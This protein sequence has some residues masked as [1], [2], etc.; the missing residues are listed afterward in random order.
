MQALCALDGGRLKHHTWSASCVAGCCN[1]LAFTLKIHHR[2]ISINQHF[3]HLFSRI[4]VAILQSCR[5]STAAERIRAEAAGPRC[6]IKP[7]SR[8]PT[9]LQPPFLCFFAVAPVIY[10]SRE[11]PEE[12]LRALKRTMSPM[13]PIVPS[14][15]NNTPALLLVFALLLPSCSRAGH[16][17]QQRG[18]RGEA[19]GPQ[20]LHEPA[21]G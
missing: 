20:A 4:P 2:S 6:C 8:I 18:P 17:Q 21:A 7:T 1:L 13:W 9:N 10:S 3:A 5:S 12:K 14:R 11:D 15:V 19:A 16:L